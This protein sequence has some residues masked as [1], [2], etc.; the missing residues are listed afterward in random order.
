LTKAGKLEINV[1]K[2]NKH[3][4]SVFSRFENPELAKEKFDCNPFSGKYNFYS[5]NDLPVNMVI[6]NC[7]M[8]FEATIS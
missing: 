7:L 1:D 3:I 5:S 8:F 6:E 4:Y 2:E